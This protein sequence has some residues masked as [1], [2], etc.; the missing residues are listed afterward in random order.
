MDKKEE[1]NEL[2][3]RAFLLK[4]GKLLGLGALS[5]FA[6]VG[7]AM[8]PTDNPNALRKEC[9]LIVTNTCS[10]NYACNYVNPHSCAVR[11]FCAD[12]QFT[13]SNVAYNRCI[14]NAFSE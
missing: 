3:R 1:S 2:N 13:C 10:L 4:T 11:F 14:G 7:K 9:S 5:H 8:S 6:F 12:D